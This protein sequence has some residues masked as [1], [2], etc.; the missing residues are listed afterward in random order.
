MGIWNPELPISRR[1]LGRFVTISTVAAALAIVDIASKNPAAV[2]KIAETLTANFGENIVVLDGTV[3]IKPFARGEALVFRS[4]PSVAPGAKLN[5]LR[6]GQTTSGLVAY[7][8]LQEDTFTIRNP[9]LVRGGSPEIAV[10]NGDGIWIKIDDVIYRH[11]YEPDG[12]RPVVRKVPAYVNVGLLTQDH[13]IL[14]G[15]GYLQKDCQTGNYIDP[16]NGGIIPS[17]QIGQVVRR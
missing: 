12:T 13:I 17:N 9:Q 6:P 16:N 15:I 10:D 7:Y 11:E 1:A 14:S 4:R 5:I 3:T 8:L 2:C